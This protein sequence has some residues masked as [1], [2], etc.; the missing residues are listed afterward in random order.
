MTVKDNYKFL[1]NRQI[2]KAQE[3]KR[4]QNAQGMSSDNDLKTI[5]TMIMIQNYQVSQ[6]DI[7]HLAKQ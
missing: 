5:I 4:L 7:R 6:K 3:I 2:K 1:S